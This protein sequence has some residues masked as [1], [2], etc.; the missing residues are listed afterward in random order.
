MGRSQ[1]SRSQR[2][3]HRGWQ[4]GQAGSGG[5]FCRW[6]GPAGQSWRSPLSRESLVFGDGS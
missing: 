5:D 2:A 4:L 6:E 3:C 1:V